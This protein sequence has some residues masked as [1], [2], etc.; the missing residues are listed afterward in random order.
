MSLREALLGCA[1]AAAVSTGLAWWLAG[2]LRRQ[3]LVDVPGERSS[4]A[5][6][7]PRGGGIAVIAGAAAGIAVLHAMQPGAAPEPWLAAAVGMMALTGLAD[8]M[9]GLPVWLRLLAQSACAA[10]VI[11]HGLVLNRMP[12]P[13]PLDLPAGVL[14]LPLTWLWLVG[15]TNL[16]NFLDGIDGYAAWQA[17]AG[18]AG[19]AM[20]GAGPA[21]SAA[22]VATGGAVAGFLVWNWHPARIFLG[23]V[24]STA[25][26]FFLAVCPLAV[27]EQDRPAAVFTMAMILW[28]FLSDGAY[29]LLKRL[30]RGEKIWTPHRGHLYQQMAGRLGRHDGVVVRVGA[31]G[32]ALGA[33]AVAA[34]AGRSAAM[35]WAV[36]GLAVAAFWAYRHVVERAAGAEQRVAAGRAGR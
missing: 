34:Y 25:L 32:T 13:A 3:G 16:Y 15:V 31:A 17:M 24:G 8:D 23:D 29:T 9:R 19:A 5:V 18:C 35:Q 26:G 2:W 6:P 36:A 14:A 21:L 11:A 22:A 27:A 12:L 33:A 30:S 10:L 28:F 4:H 1:A 7:T 20:L